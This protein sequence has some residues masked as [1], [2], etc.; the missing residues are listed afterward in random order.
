MPFINKLLSDSNDVSHKRVVSIY[1][2]ILLTIVIVAIL[3]GVVVPSE[4]IYSLVTL[5]A[6]ESILTV[7]PKNNQ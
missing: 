4:L 2:L 5:I 3:N 6:G 1:S 7:M